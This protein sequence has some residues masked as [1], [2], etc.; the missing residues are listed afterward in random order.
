M[1]NAALSCIGGAGK[2]FR[3]SPH[4]NAGREN[5]RRKKRLRGETVPEP[6]TERASGAP[7]LPSASLR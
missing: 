4:E 6:E 5:G 2:N 7:Y 3:G 1:R